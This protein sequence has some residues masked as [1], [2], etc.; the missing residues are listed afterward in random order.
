[1]LRLGIYLFKI[2]SDISIVPRIQFLWTMRVG[3]AIETN[4]N[5][6]YVVEIWNYSQQFYLVKRICEEHLIVREFKNC[7]IPDE[8]KFS[9][10]Q[11]NVISLFFYWIT[12]MD[13]TSP[14]KIRIFF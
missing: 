1:M 2:R 4:E 6:R 10:F 9:K 14:R 13:L 8:T 5:T 7:T 3:T 12:N 11:K